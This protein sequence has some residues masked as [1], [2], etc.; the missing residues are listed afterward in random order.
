MAVSPTPVIFE[1]RDPFFMEQHS[2][3]SRFAL[4]KLASIFNQCF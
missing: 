1:L 4:G 2:L 3:Q